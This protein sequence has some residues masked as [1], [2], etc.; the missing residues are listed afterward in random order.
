MEVSKEIK[1]WAAGFFDGE[2][3]VQISKNLAPSISASNTDIRAI[4]V[5]YRSWGGIVSCQTPE[6][7]RTCYTV[8]YDGDKAKPIAE[9]LLP[10]VQIKREQLELIL[11]YIDMVEVFRKHCRKAHNRMDNVE[12]DYRQA[13]YSK[14]IEFHH[15]EHQDILTSGN[16]MRL[17]K[18]CKAKEGK[19]EK[20]RLFWKTLNDEEIKIFG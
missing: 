15:T 20:M 19:N 16:A 12:L 10:Y 7:G 3:N 13:V 2:G 6:L 11:E 18:Y 14:I 8:R 9:D 5:F 1:I 4:M 17:H